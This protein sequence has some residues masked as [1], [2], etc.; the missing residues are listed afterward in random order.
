MCAAFGT[1]ECISKKWTLHPSVTLPPY[2][3]RPRNRLR[4][5]TGPTGLGSRRLSAIG[6]IFAPDI[7]RRN[8]QLAQRR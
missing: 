8:H 6:A 5:G 3:Y 4:R 7:V 2:L 1:V